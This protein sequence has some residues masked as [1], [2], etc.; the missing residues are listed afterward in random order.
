MEKIFGIVQLKFLHLFILQPQLYSCI[1]VIIVTKQNA[2][3]YGFLLGRILVSNPDTGYHDRF[4]LL[5]IFPSR[6]TPV[7]YF[8]SVYDHFHPHTRIIQLLPFHNVL[9]C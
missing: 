3:V 8:T 6:Q 2:V 5:L 4:F 1:M 9:N 7:R